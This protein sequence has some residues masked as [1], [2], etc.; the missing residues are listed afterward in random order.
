M[1][2]PMQL[3]PPSLDRLPSYVAALKRGWSPDNVK[4][5][6]ASI[7]E[8]A[9]IEKLGIAAAFLPWHNRI[10]NSISAAILRGPLEPLNEDTAVV[11]YLFLVV[12]RV[13]HAGNRDGTAWI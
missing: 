2:H 4:G 8:L 10:A 3:L 6:A 7:E 5:A 11:A 13:R 9:H 12:R 1:T